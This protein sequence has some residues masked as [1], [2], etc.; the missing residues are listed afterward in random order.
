MKPVALLLVLVLAACRGGSDVHRDRVT[1]APVTTRV[2]PSLV[3]TLAVLATGREPAADELATMQRAIDGRTLTMAAYIDQ[4]VARPE[5]TH[6]VA[7][8]AVLRHLLDQN[9]ISTPMPYVVKHTE[10]ATPVYYVQAPCPVERAVSVRPWWDLDH[11]VHVCPDAYRPDTWQAKTPPGQHVV[12]CAS[13]LA[14]SIS[15][16]GGC[17]CGPNLFRCYPSREARAA[18]QEALRQE[19]RLTVTYAVEHDL[20]VSSVFVANETFRPRAAEQVLRS[21]IIEQQRVRDPLAMLQELAH[22]PV[23]GKWAPRD[24]HVAGQHAGLLT[25]PQVTMDMPDR[26]QRMNVIYDVLWCSEGNS[27]GAT[28]EALLALHTGGDLEIQSAGWKELAARPIC[29]NCHARLDYGMQFFYGF[30]NASYQPFF[31][32]DLQQR[33]RGPLYAHDIDDPRGDA[34]LTP[35]GFARLATSQP[36]FKHCMARDFGE[37]VLGN[38]VRSE[39]LEAVERVMQHDRATVHDLMRASLLALVGDWDARRGS[40]LP[41]VPIAD[42]PPA[43]DEVTVPAPLHQLVEDECGDC[44]DATPERPD[45]SAAQLPRITIV[46]MLDEVAYGRMPKDHAMAP[47]RRLA[48]L[49]GFVTATWRG[50]S[51]ELARASY[52]A[53]AVTLPALRPEVIMSLVR[54]QVGA[55][56]APWRMMENQVRSDHQQVTPGLIGITGLAIIEACRDRYHERSAIDRCIADTMRLDALAVRPH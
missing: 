33:G 51:A 26:R 14:F 24:E 31:I 28:P 47:A 11:E 7:P 50:K 34:E 41:A 46:A 15:D 18:A 54:Q 19:L 29:T 25:S 32:P 53:R 36:E 45:L 27:V 6:T 30:P 39:Q 9:A 3:R 17:G 49:D 5:F 37:Y 21:Q 22:W 20:P 2:D 52:L 48:F 4:L 40:D 42:T 16:T 8:L 44:H 38:L 43:A 35:Q 1:P 23:D 13:G 56:V 12:A 55:D 10:G